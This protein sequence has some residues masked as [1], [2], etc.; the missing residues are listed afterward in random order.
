M[1]AV[2]VSLLLPVP[3]FA[4]DTPVGPPGSQVATEQTSAA[5]TNTDELRKATQNPKEQ[6]KMLMEQELKQMEQEQQQKK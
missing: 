3:L 4:Q 6:Q 5:A 1:V 2:A